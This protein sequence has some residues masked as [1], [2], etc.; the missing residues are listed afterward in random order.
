MP[1]PEE[2]CTWNST[3]LDQLVE[4]HLQLRERWSSF[5]PTCHVLEQMRRALQ[6]LNVD[7]LYHGALGRTGI[8]ER[9]SRVF[10]SEPGLLMQLRKVALAELVQRERKREHLE[11]GA[12]ATGSAPW[13]PVLS[14][15][16]KPTLLEEAL[17]LHPDAFDHFKRM[18]QI[19]VDDDALERVLERDKALVLATVDELYRC[20]TPVQMVSMADLGDSGPRTADSL[21][22]DTVPLSRLEATLRYLERY[23]GRERDGRPHG[24]GV[25]R[26]NRVEAPRKADYVSED[27][28]AMSKEEKKAWQ[29]CH[30]ALG[31]SQYSLELLRCYVHEFSERPLSNQDTLQQVVLLEISRDALEDELQTAIAWYAKERLECRA[32]LLQLLHRFDFGAVEKMFASASSI[33]GDASSEVLDMEE[34][35]PWYLDFTMCY[36]QALHELSLDGCGLRLASLASVSPTLYALFRRLVRFLVL[37]EYEQ[38]PETVGKNAWQRKMRARFPAELYLSLASAACTRTKGKT[39]HLAARL[40]AGLALRREW[41]A[42]SSLCMDRP[43]SHER[44]LSMDEL[45]RM[46]IFEA[47]IIDE[48]QLDHKARAAHARLLEWLQ[49]QLTHLLGNDQLLLGLPATVT[50]SQHS[51]Q[52]SDESDRTLSAAAETTMDVDEELVSVIMEFT[53]VTRAEAIFILRE[54]M[55]QNPGGRVSSAQEIL[56][57]L[58]P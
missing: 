48:R 6:G 35:A 22:Y 5:R 44:F 12:P 28:A 11:A 56:D 42:K 54:Y 43:Q 13:V 32:K 18:L 24:T 9:A 27:H 4:E 40:E 17:N 51:V 26:A 49:Q 15:L 45:E 53:D 41:L 29:V 37:A 1:K 58:F 34:K 57:R 30:D 20:C 39:S 33:E 14:Y 7:E 46:N 10:Q 16:R 31:I 36:I 19:L 2:Q 52:M 23:Y 38:E 3:L 21:G 8:G 47:P 25:I 50:I 55:R